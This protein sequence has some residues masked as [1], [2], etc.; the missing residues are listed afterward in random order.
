M[1]V[2]GRLAIGAGVVFFVA[3]AYLFLVLGGAGW[4]LEMF[5]DPSLLLD[6]VHEHQKLYQGLW[7][8]YFVSQALLLLVPWRLGEQLG[9]RAVG[10]LG[11]IAVAIAIVG[12]VVIFA[13]SPV[14][15][16]AY[17]D[18][19][20]AG[21]LVLHE[22]AA[23]LGKYLRLFSQLLLGV[24]MVLAGRRLHARTGARLWWLFGALGAWT[25]LVSAW[26]LLDPLMPLEDWLG[27]LLGL[28][29]LGLGIGLLRT[30][31]RSATSAT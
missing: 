4:T 16:R 2:T 20:G 30:R 6:W 12:L 29:Y 27:F 19:G 28:G 25:L 31:N 3:N 5:D 1:R 21:V 11:T 26:K 14:T 24:W 17:Q 22:L 13:A 9:E 18:V 10:L 8:L 15:A 23:D 7:L